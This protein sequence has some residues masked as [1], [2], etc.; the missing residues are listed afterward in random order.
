MNS[1]NIFR[2]GDTCIRFPRDATSGRLGMELLPASL[3]QRAMPRR[4]TLRGL[5]FIDAMPGAD[6]WPASVV[7]SLVQFKLVGDPYPGAFAQGHTMRNSPGID[8]F[9]CSGQTVTRDGSTT[10]VLT[11]LARADGCRV[12]HRILAREGEDA[13][14]VSTTF[15]NGSPAPVTLEMLSSFSLGGI[16]PFAPDDAPGRLRVHRFRSAWSAEGR[17]ETRSLED[18]HLERSWSGAGAFS[19]RFGQVGTMPVRRWFP[20]VAI[21]DTES[22]VLWGAQLA[23]AG[24]WQME[25][26]RQHDD[27]CLSGGLADREFGHWLKTLAPGESITA[28][29]SCV[30]CVRGNLDALCDRMT[31][32]QHRAADTHPAIERDLPIV[33]NEWCTTWGDPSHENLLTIAGRL[34]DSEVRYLVIDAG[35]YKGEG[36]DWNSGHGDWVPSSKLFPNGLKETAGAIRAHGLVP[37]LWFEM[38]T[39]G[40]KSTAFSLTDRLLKRDGVPVTVRQRRFWDLNEPAAVE[41]LSRR[42]IDLL[43]SCGFGYLKVDYNETAGLGCDGAESQG[44]GLRRQVEG[45]YRFFER[46]R[47][48]LPELV[49]ENCSSGGHRLEPSMLARTAMSSFS[50][51]HE[52]VEI[53]IIAANLHRLLLPRQSQIWAVLHAA[54]SEQ[55]LIYSLAATFL[56]RM[57]LSGEVTTLSARQWELVRTAMRLYQRAAPI[58]KHGTSRRFGEW[59]ASWR[60]PRDWQAVVYSSGDRRSAMVVIHAFAGAPGAVALPLPDGTRWTSVDRFGAAPVVA[61][62]TAGNA[63]RVP[64]AGDFSAQVILLEADRRADADLPAN[65][66]PAPLHP[67]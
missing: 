12:E 17:L 25:V 64:L 48:R 63:L 27:V 30:A 62:I 28:P 14:E 29:P 61:S 23:W 52:L 5:P 33:F 32:V 57:C 51:A 40:E 50:D 37:G 54:D 35:W 56:G 26:F 41:Y 18:L 16:T 66:P 53:P 8:A 10:T 20:F 24:S 47:A 55:R 11:T 44:E 2:F 22:G 13:F 7:E 19:E 15:I 31:A 59:G 36:S 42:V 1:L 38:E 45:V 60:H 65:P 49:I 46:I 3:E 6:P 39:V 21:E 67:S 58:I 43:E 4:A 34:R 9:S